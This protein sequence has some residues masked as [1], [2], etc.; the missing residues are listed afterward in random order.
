MGE[1]LVVVGADAAGMTAA[2]QVRRRNRDFEVIAY[3]MGNH[4]S[5]AACGEPYYIAGIIDPIDRLIARTPEQFARAGIELHLRHEVTAI[6]LDR[7][8]VEVWDTDGETS[9]EKGFDHLMVSTGARAFVPPMPGRDLDGVHTLRTLGDAAALR[10]IA[11]A[12][13]GNAV[14]VG[15][16]YI[17]LEAAEAFHTK[18][19]N[20]TIVEGLPAVLP[21]TLDSDLGDQ[22]AEAVRSM[23]ITVLTG[24]MVEQIDGTDHVTGVSIEGGNL[25]ADVVVLSIGSRPVVEIARDAGIPLGE[26]GAIAVDDRQRTGIEG[27]WSA[28]D[29]A[30]TQHRVTGRPA[31]L[32]LATV[33]HGMPATGVVHHGRLGPVGLVPVKSIFLNLTVKSEQAF[34][35]APGRI[36]LIAI[37]YGEVG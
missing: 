33:A 15:G 31:N 3:E 13:S 19:W 9:V 10:S 18:G 32:H 7:R 37:V 11:D 36:T 23:G 6:D 21:R 34:V 12:G 17:G 20:V 24:A 22:V 16:G 8:V 2:S 35:I 25:P 1:R 5:Y 27:V 29:C 26:T 30:E 14:I 28:G 4:A